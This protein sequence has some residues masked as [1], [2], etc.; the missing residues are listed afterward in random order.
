[1]SNFDF[2]DKA[3]S[4]IADAIQLAK[5]NGNAQGGCFNALSQA[6]LTPFAVYPLHFASVL[7]N[8]D[9]QSP[10]LFSSVI[11]KAGGEPV[12]AFAR[13]SCVPHLPP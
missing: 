12:S 13:R 9:A 7:L 10:G 8:D 2:T 11:S 1:M 6:P 3:Q 4:T 5:D